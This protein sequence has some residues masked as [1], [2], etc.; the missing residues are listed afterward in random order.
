MEQLSDAGLM[1]IT[2]GSRQ[3]DV[4]SARNLRNF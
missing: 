3:T 1:R 4:T 2:M